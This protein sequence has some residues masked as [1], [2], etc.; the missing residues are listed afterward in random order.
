MGNCIGQSWYAE[1]AERGDCVLMAL[2]AD[3]RI[4]ANLDIRGRSGGWRVNELLARF[5]EPVDPA[6][7]GH[8]TRWVATL[9]PREP[10]PGP[11]APEPPVRT[12]GGTARGTRLP[13]A[14]VRALTA[15]VARTLTTVTAARRVYAVLASNLGRHADFEPEAA[16]IALKRLGMAQYVDLLRT[17]LATGQSAAALW[18]ASGVRPL[19]TAVARLGHDRVAALAE[20]APLPRTLRALVRRPEIAPAYAMDVVARATR[21][22]MGALRDDEALTRSVARRPT[23]EL[24]CALVIATT[25]DSTVDAVRVTAPGTTAVPGYPATDVLDEQ[26]PWQRSLPAAADLGAPVATF[27]AAV[28]ERGL[29]APATLLGKG[30]WAA[31]WSRAHR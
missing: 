20:D 11:A 25:C 4:V 23:S 12:R 8:V 19:A 21:T 7:A 9:A 28:A 29:H 13:T 30:G 15:E 26:G 5:N 16:V 2:R 10:M 27:E 14:L 1:D 6:L 24:V 22:A 3:G 31:L 17:S 18:R